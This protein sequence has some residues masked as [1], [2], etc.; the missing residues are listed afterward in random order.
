MS[1]KTIGTTGPFGVGAPVGR[2]APATSPIRRRP[3]APASRTGTGN[4]NQFGATAPQVPPPPAPA[5]E[6]AVAAGPH[7]ASPPAPNAAFEAMMQFTEMLE[8]EVAEAERRALAHGREWR[9]P[10]SNRPDPDSS[11]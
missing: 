9:V 5:G 1:G 4:R 7:P 10:V 3:P 11:A 8:Q 6:V 2:L